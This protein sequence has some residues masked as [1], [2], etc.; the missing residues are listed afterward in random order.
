M[1]VGQPE[2]VTAAAQ[3]KRNRRADQARADDQHAA[4][5]C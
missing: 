3:R 4:R 1:N 2:L 5:R